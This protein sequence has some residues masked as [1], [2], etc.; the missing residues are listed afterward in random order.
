MKVFQSSLCIAALFSAPLAA[1]D[2]GR[3]IEMTLEVESIE[4][5]EPKVEALLRRFG[6]YAEGSEA[7]PDWKK[8]LR[9]RVST[10]SLDDFV[11]K[12]RE[13][14]SVLEERHTAKDPTLAMASLNAEISSLLLDERGL[15][16][17]LA[18]LGPD[19]P[20]ALEVEREIG[21]VRTKRVEL[22]AKAKVLQD[23]LNYGSV[24]LTLVEPHEEAFSDLL[25]GAFQDLLQD[26]LATTKR[27]LAIFLGSLFPL[28]A[29]ICLLLVVLLRKTISRR[30][31]RS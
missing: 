27:S 12:A 29:P 18:W 2:L 23:R 28:A 21:S 31:Q 9:L 13:L 8:I 10:K 11:K 6:G 14:G 4:G 15:L 24:T 26:P 30:G 7:G 3:H 20:L 1:Q 17:H 5:S 25:S 19:D 16:E 22:E